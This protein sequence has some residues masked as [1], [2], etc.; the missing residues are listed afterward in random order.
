MFQS[1]IKKQSSEN[2]IITFSNLQSLNDTHN[3]YNIKKLNWWLKMV[4]DAMG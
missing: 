4:G 1:T 3:M 2:L